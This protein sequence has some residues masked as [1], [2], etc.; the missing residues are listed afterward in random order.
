M[1]ILDFDVDDMHRSIELASPSQKICETLQ[2]N[3]TVSLLSI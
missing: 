3:I 2:T 1:I